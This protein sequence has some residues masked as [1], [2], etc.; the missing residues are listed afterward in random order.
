MRCGRK[1]SKHETF[2]MHVCW[3]VGHLHIYLEINPS[4]TFGFKFQ[5]LCTRS[6]V[7]EYGTQRPVTCMGLKAAQCT[8]GMKLAAIKVGHF[9]ISSH[10][11]MPAW[12]HF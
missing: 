5:A 3:C 12:S 10:L 11:E 1:I 2:N 9:C 7:F 8:E 6:A 4:L